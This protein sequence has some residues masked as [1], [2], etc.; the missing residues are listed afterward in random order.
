MPFEDFIAFFD[1]YAICMYEKTFTLSS[2]SEHLDAEYKTCYKFRVSEPGE[3]FISV[4]QPDVRGF[5]TLPDGKSNT[6]VS[7]L[8]TL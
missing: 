6:R 8:L 2:F 3:Y 4:S 7:L 1:Q 5:P